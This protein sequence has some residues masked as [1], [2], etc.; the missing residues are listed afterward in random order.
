MRLLMTL[1]LLAGSACPALAGSL[2]FE[3]ARASA[4]MIEASNAQVSAR[5]AG[6]INCPTRACRS[7][8]TICR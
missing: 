2:T 8:S 6:A 3:Q 4:P 5:A 1:P 7:A